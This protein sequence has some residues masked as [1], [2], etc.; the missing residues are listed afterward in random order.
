MKKGLE[1][2]IHREQYLDALRQGVFPWK[3][4][5]YYYS[6]NAPEGEKP[7]SFISFKES[8]SLDSM[9]AG[10]NKFEKVS[11]PIYETLDI[12]YSP[13]TLMTSDNKF[14]KLI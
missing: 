1:Y 3:P 8:L 13:V 6:L 5:Y 9:S 14:I 2:D 12:Y 11:L 7:Q 4:A 10:D